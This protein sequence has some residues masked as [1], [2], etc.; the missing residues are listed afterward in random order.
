MHSFAW[1]YNPQAAQAFKKHHSS[2]GK[3]Q[4]VDQV[5][6]FSSAGSKQ[7]FYLYNDMHG[8]ILHWHDCNQPI[9]SQNLH[10]TV[11]I[12]FW[13][14]S[15]C[16]HSHPFW[17]PHLKGV[18]S[19]AQS[20]PEARTHEMYHRHCPSTERQVLWAKQGLRTQLYSPGKD[21]W[22]N[23]LHIH[24]FWDQKELQYLQLIMPAYGL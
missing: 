10:P 21:L 8:S 20:W 17:G 2:E 3:D 7:T 5:T 4:G 16:Q 12:V 15:F 11:S 9:Y 13:L 23:I 6:K 14:S 19:E 24:S 1:Q 22:R 18:S